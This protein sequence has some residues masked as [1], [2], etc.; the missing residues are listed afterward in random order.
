MNDK[1]RTAR[2]RHA[3]DVRKI[4]GLREHMLSE[5]TVCLE[6]E[7]VFSDL[8]RLKEFDFLEE[9][10]IRQLK[11]GIAA[12][13][14][15]QRLTKLSLWEIRALDFSFVRTMRSLVDLH[16]YGIKFKA[17]CLPSAPN[18]LR[19]ITLRV[20]NGFGGQLDVS[21]ATGLETLTLEGC[22]HI[23]SLTDCRD[24]ENLRHV[25]LSNIRDL[26]SLSELSTA[27]NLESVVVQLTPNLPVSELEWMLN[28][29]SL[30]HVYPLLDSTRNSPRMKDLLE[31]LAPKFGSSL[32]DHTEWLG[33]HQ[34]H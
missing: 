13:G 33:Q 20:C 2:I 7:K 27:P 12:V 5:G 17:F 19:H 14:G 10:S 3:H 21:D 11:K 16:C 8:S 18:A 26:D 9:L 6:V 22:G 31:M 34:M 23:A 29:R 15:L 32:F 28:H 30:K 4:D 25:S 24:L 1:R